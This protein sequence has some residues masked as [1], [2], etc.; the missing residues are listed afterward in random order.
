MQLTLR[1]YRQT[2][3]LSS[4]L[5][6]P[7]SLAQNTAFTI[8]QSTLKH[9]TITDE[10][11][12]THLLASRACS[13]RQRKVTHTC[14][15]NVPRRGRHLVLVGRAAALLAGVTWCASGRSRRALPSRRPES[16]CAGAAQ[17]APP[18]G[19]RRLRSERL[20]S[21]A[22]VHLGCVMGDERRW[23]LADPRRLATQSVRKDKIL[24]DITNEYRLNKSA[25]R[26]WAIIRSPN[27][28]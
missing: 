26:L 23:R 8:A 19:T 25:R 9:A 7:H 1:L 13:R 24:R 11:R 20:G 16:A 3:Q 18:T 10:K 2:S 22:G 17:P 14:M 21:A 5:R 4:S 28:V 27:T 15:T 6:T 12:I